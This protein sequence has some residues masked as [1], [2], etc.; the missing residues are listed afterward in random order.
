MRIQQTSAILKESHVER[1]QHERQVH[2]DESWMSKAKSL[3]SDTTS[4][5][6]GFVRNL[7]PGKHAE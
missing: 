2:H 4:K 6:T 5:V 1:V 7:M 3:F